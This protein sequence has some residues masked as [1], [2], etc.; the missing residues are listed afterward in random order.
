MNSS[1]HC[2]F[3]QRLLISHYCPTDTIQ[4]PGGH[5]TSSKTLSDITRLGTEFTG[6][7]SWPSEE[8]AAA[9]A[10]G[11][12]TAETARPRR[13]FRM[14]EERHTALERKA[15][16]NKSSQK[17]MSA[18]HECIKNRDVKSSYG[19]PG[20]CR[21][22]SHCKSNLNRARKWTAIT[23]V[24]IFLTSLHFIHS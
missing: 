8:R 3:C 19:N 9:A 1:K 20:E 6:K 7:R 13:P 24:P 18:D 17:K 11:R 10:C 16:Q 22:F 12:K 14:G 5:V 21:P 23:R 2:S 15:V 4:L